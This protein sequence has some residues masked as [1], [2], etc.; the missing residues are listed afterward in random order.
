MEKK[1]AKKEELEQRR[2]GS[3]AREMERE[4]VRMSAMV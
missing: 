1:E 3:F 2:I 4:G